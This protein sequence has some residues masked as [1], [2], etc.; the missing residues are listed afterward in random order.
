MRVR[1]NN[2]PNEAQKKILRQEC[3]KEFDRLIENMNRDV[4][5]QLLHFFKFKRG[6]GQKRLEAL[7]KDLKEAL[8][9]IHARYELSE[10]DTAWICERQ[11]IDSGI[12]ISRLLEDC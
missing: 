10:S 2:K 8:E 3:I 1:I 9:G 5:I 12:D 6:Y 4:Y 7:S 11:L